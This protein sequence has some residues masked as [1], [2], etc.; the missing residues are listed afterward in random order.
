MVTTHQRILILLLCVLL[1]AFA[2][3]GCDDWD[4]AD[5]SGFAATSTASAYH[6]MARATA[7]AMAEGVLEEQSNIVRR[8]NVTR[9]D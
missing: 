1:A 8:D 9:P 3:L 4:G 5:R 7:D 2:L 6:E